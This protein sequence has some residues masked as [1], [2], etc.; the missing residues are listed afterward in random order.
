ML[1]SKTMNVLWIPSELSVS[2]LLLCAF[3]E[4]PFLV[5]P[6]LAVVISP[7]KQST[8]PTSNKKAMF[9]IWST[10]LEPEVGELNF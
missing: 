9:F 7:P 5:I 10:F 4:K 2:C 3:I 8:R 6:T 1:L